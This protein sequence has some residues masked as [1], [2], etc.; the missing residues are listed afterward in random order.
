MTMIKSG[1]I[2]TGGI[3]YFQARTIDDV[4]EL[5]DNCYSLGI[6]STVSSGSFCGRR[7]TR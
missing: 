2:D 5:L 1:P 6:K 7:T 4:P 3:G